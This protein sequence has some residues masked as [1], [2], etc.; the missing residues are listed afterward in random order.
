MG[1]GR[2]RASGKS[3]SEPVG[4]WPS[5]ARGG[6]AT[7]ASVGARASAR[8]L[9]GTTGLLT[10][11]ELF[12]GVPLPGLER[13]VF[14]G[15]ETRTGTLLQAA[16]EIQRESGSLAHR[17]L[18]PLRRELGAIDR[19]IRHGTLRGAGETISKVCGGPDLKDEHAHPRQTLERLTADMRDFARRARAGRLVV[20]NLAST[21]P[22]TRPPA[23]LAS[24][25]S[26]RR[27]LASRRAPRLAPSTLYAL[28]AFEAGAAF[29]NFTP[30][31]GALAPACEELA[32]EQ[33]LPYMGSDGKTGETL[34]KSALAPMFRYRNLRV[35]AWEG[36]NILGDRDG[37]VLADARN[38]SAKVATK[39]ALLPRILGYPLHT[40]VGIDYVPSLGDRKTA[41][42]FIHFQGF[43]DFQMS[44]QFSWHGCD[45]ILAAPLVLDMVRLAEL[46][47]SRGEAGRMSWLS[48]Y[49]KKPLGVEEHNLHRQWHLLGAYVE[50]LAG[51]RSPSGGSGSLPIS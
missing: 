6:R 17:V 43:L 11:T 21:E 8:G 16:E 35:L 23:C 46:A 12:E 13:L 30:S 18:H 45:A 33:G 41:W 49:F 7:T 15:H 39:D 14:G 27:A 26:L 10:A 36:Y 44:M 28:A 31:R 42:D 20:V 34:V 51:P 38:R 48:V 50:R 5:G 32:R 3:G 19:E 37:A 47:L 22:K 4:V 25:A 9:A 24:L 29:I 40:H 2:K 1:S